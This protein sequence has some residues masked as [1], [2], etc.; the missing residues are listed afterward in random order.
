[1]LSRVAD[2]IYWLNRYIERAENTARFIAVNFILTLDT[3]EERGD[4]W[5]PLIYASGDEELFQERYGKATKEHVIQF[6]TFDTHNPNS[7]LSCLTAARENARSIREIISS[8]MWEQVN[9]F[10]LYVNNSAC[11]DT[12]NS[13][14]FFTQIKLEAHLFVGIMEVTMSHNEAWH[15]GRMGRMLERAD[16]TSRIVDVKYFT[17]LPKVDDIGSPLDSEQWA[18]VLKSVS[19]LE[20][21]RKKY[22]LITPLEVAEFLILDREFPRSIFYSVS[23]A[24]RSLH[25]ITET[26][27]GEYSNPAEKSLGKLRS[28]LEYMDIKEIIAFGLHE[29]MDSIQRKINGV[30]EQIFETFFAMRTVGDE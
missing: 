14:D 12:A 21:Y 8:E 30:G 25:E 13:Y 27:V 15:F 24:Q 6:L 11:T 26:P 29:F 5:M 16:K 7:I 19:G 22:H 17:L 10:Y 28:E 18:A 4:Q 3:A 20:M 23:R 9:R 1:M 2:S